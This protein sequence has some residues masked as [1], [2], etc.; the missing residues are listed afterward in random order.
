[1]TNFVIGKLGLS[2]RFD[3]PEHNSGWFSAADDTARL[4]VNLS[5][6]NP[7]DSFYIVGNNDLDTLKYEK[8][9][10]LFPHNN[11]HNTYNTEGVFGKNYHR[12]G[13][14]TPLEYLNKNSINIDYGI[15]SFGSVL[16]RNIPNKTYTK[17]GT[18]AKPLDRAIKY[19]APYVNVLNELGIEWVCLIDDPRHFYNKI[20][21]L[22]NKP[23]I[24]LSQVKGSHPYECI[25]SYENQD[26]EIT[27][28][29]IKYSYVETTVALDEIIKPISDSWRYRKK[30]VSLVCNEAGSDEN[31]NSTKKL[32]NACRPRYP[33]VKE[34]I[35][36][37]FDNPIIYGKWCDDII[38][39]NTAFKGTINR[40]I[41]Y[42]EMMKWKHSLCI[43][44]D[45]GWA[46]AKYLECLKCGVSPFMH[47]EYDD[48]RNTNIQDFYRVSSVE[49]FKDKVAMSD[50]T[51]I[52][53]INK[54]I[55]NC[56]SDEYISGQ[57]IND[58]IYSALD[59]ERNIKNKVRNLWTPQKYNTL[60]NFME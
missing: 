40:R 21:D 56:L 15:I 49:E 13:W 36:S 41:L 20:L 19:V 5:Y 1:M 46:T 3:F 57:R 44:I 55:K 32:G 60:E 30:L 47:P 27:E 51:H 58:D 2:V 18:I 16:T 11:V 43:P 22:F 53:E 28:I 48:Q 6:N 42:P 23:K 52:E 4:V 29:P 26:L 50:D 45:K 34:W 35:L 9:K 31:I 8:R 59:I 12:S 54:G 14:E 25:Q 24:F 10:R 37:S 33:M 39:S 17:S 7:N 38:R